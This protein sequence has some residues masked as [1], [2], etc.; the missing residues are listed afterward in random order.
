MRLGA[1]CI[2]HVN[3]LTIAQEWKSISSNF[4]LSFAPVIPSIRFAWILK[5]QKMNFTFFIWVLFGPD[6]THIQTMPDPRTS[7]ATQLP[8]SALTQEFP[9]WFNYS[10]PSFS[11]TDDD[12]GGDGGSPWFTL[13]RC[14][15]GFLSPSQFHSSAIFLFPSPSRFDSRRTNRR[16]GCRGCPS[17]YDCQ[18]IDGGGIR[19]GLDCKRERKL[20]PLCPSWIKP[21]GR[22]TVENGTGMEHSTYLTRLDQGEL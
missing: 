7:N 10:S 18:S 13:V 12:G 16:P 2:L 21:R 9:S 17:R 8:T 14:A 5:Q 15:D 3:D 11:V 4:Y 22:G 20:P 6:P 19:K 1:L